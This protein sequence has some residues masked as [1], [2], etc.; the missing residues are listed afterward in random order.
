MT[1]PIPTRRPFWSTVPARVFALIVVAAVAGALMGCEKR[2]QSV[3]E[4]L[5]ALETQ[6]G[7]KACK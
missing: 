5:D 3:S 6:D 7:K 1:R 2:Q 4:R